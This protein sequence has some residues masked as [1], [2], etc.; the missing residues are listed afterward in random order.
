MTDH[1]S[2]ELSLRITGEPAS[3]TVHI[4]GE[5]D[6]DTSDALVDAVAAHLERH[7]EPG[8][9]RLDF[10]DLTWVDSSGLS[11]LIMIHRH[12]SAIGADL[13]LDNRPELLD[14]RLRLTNLLA[15]LTA[16]AA[17][18]GVLGSEADGDARA[19]VI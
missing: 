11:A 1:S 5:L 8:A 13:Y 9:V 14:H 4:V 3:W 15:H 10:R 12:T 19:G 2:N 7:P 18:D 17:D 16:P 6:Y